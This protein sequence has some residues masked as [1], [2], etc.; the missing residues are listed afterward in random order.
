MKEAKICPS[1]HTELVKYKR[2]NI[3][4]KYLF[5]CPSCKLI[6]KVLFCNC[7]LSPMYIILKY[8]HYHIPICSNTNCEQFE[9]V[10]LNFK[11][12]N[13]RIELP[14][15][16]Y[17]DP[18]S[19]IMIQRVMMLVRISMSRHFYIYNMSGQLR[20]HLKDVELRLLE[21][22]S[23]KPEKIKPEIYNKIRSNYRHF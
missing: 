21:N 4:N 19:E 3:N 5:I 23:Y 8:P 14:V 13:N 1:C 2:H 18:E 12:G 22:S 10:V 11:Y 16:K 20:K 6:S 15:I 9:L 7:C 17:K